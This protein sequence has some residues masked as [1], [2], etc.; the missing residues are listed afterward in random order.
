MLKTL[1]FV[2]VVLSLSSYG[3]TDSFTVKGKIDASKQ[4]GKRAQLFVSKDKLLLYQF[5]VTLGSTYSVALKRGSYK[6]AV[7]S[8]KLCE[9]SKQV[10]I[11]GNQKL[12]FLLKL[13]NQ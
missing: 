4:C 13:E 2:L 3:A 8:E 7:L 5:D 11:T 9:S 10:K 6:L 12:D 1:I